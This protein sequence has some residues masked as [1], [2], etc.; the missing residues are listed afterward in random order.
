MTLSFGVSAEAGD[1]AQRRS[2]AGL[3]A[4]PA[5]GKVTSS[6]GIEE[7]L[8]GA[9]EGAV[10]VMLKVLFFSPVGSAGDDILVANPE[11][12]SLFCPGELA[13]TFGA[14]KTAATKARRVRLVEKGT[15][16][17]T[18]NQAYDA[19][20]K[21]WAISLHQGGKETGRVVLDAVSYTHL[22]LPTTPYV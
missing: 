8:N 16:A 11:G 13:A 2:A 19:S 5:Q 12:T 10:N 3:S 4:C 6:S 7:Q 20:A 17:F 18:L 21:T 22:T 14:V 9:V 1:L 15:P